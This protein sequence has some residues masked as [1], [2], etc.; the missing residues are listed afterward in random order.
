[1]PSDLSIEEIEAEYDNARLQVYRK[2]IKRTA[3]L[4]DEFDS[5]N[6][7]EHMGITEAEPNPFGFGQGD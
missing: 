5:L 6:Q 1:M 3:Q 7:Y 4:H 2:W